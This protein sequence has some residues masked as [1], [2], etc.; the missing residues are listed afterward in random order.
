MQVGKVAVVVGGCGFLGRH[1][2]EGLVARGYR[3]RAFDLRTTFT[4]EG[5]EFHTGNLCQKEDLLPVLRG[6]NVVFHTASP[7]PSSNDRELFYTVNVRGTQTLLGA[8]LQAGVRRLV[9]TSSASVVY[10]GTDIQNGTEDLPYAAS[11]MDYYTET[12]ILQE[13]LVLEFNDSG[14]ILT[15]A[16]RPHG[17]F[18][19]RD[20][21]MLPTVVNT[22]RAGK[23]KFII[24]WVF[25]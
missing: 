1:L 11:P 6:A 21:Q 10:E 20:P 7:P 17:I 4:Q 24:G 14:R 15:V 9:L 18:G 8:C 12:K 3:V 19:P 5:V 2:V 25:G 22:A 16:V 23:M 13:K